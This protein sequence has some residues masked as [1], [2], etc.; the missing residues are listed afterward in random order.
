LQELPGSDF[1]RNDAY[2]T[3]SKPGFF[4]VWWVDD[5]A[6]QQVV[7]HVSGERHDVSRPLG[8][9][10][11]IEGNQLWGAAIKPDHANSKMPTAAGTS[12]D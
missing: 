5:E 11:A 10:F 2:E 12:R 8:M 7:F 1:G 9:V 4:K 6:N 3:E